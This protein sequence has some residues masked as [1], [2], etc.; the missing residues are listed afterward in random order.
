MDNVQTVF[1]VDLCSLCNYP[2]RAQKKQ[3]EET[4]RFDYY[5]QISDAGSFPAAFYPYL[6]YLCRNMSFS[7]TLTII[8]M[9]IR[10]PPT[11]K[12]HVRTSPKRTTPNT[13]DVRGCSG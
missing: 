8:P 10:T 1:E 6:H 13:A 3:P 11:T 7:I 9:Q 12:F 2:W 4:G 5:T